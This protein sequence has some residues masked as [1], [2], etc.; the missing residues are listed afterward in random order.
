MDNKES[1]KGRPPAQ[2]SSVQLGKTNKFKIRKIKNPK[3]RKIFYKHPTAEKQS[4]NYGERTVQ[5][6]EMQLVAALPFVMIVPSV[7]LA[8]FP[9]LLELNKAFLYSFVSV[10]WL[11]LF[12]PLLALFG[13]KVVY[14]H[15]INRALFKH[16]KA[17]KT[18]RFVSILNFFRNK[19]AFIVDI[20]LFAVSIVSVIVFVIFN[21]KQMDNIAI[22]AI[23]FSLIL[24][25]LNLH[26]YFNDSIFELR[27]K[28]I[29]NK[30][31]VEKNE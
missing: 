27:K 30:E 16:S 4:S 2:E 26:I 10:F 20:G 8:V 29:K 7:I 24:L 15:N 11:T 21:L 23:L 19:A 13:L 14:R 31:D 18:Y 1:Q 9:L 3:K 22:T 12:F 5:N 6:R 25:F 17:Y 28:Y